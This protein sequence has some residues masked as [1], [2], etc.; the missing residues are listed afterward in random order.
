MRDPERIVVALAMLG[1]PLE[2]EAK[3]L[4]ADLG[5]TAY[6]VRLKLTAGL[7]AIVLSTVDEDAARAVLAKL[8]ARGHRALLVHAAAVVPHSAMV[9]MR[10]FELEPD[11]LVQTGERLPWGEI[12]ALVRARHHHQHDSVE[13]VKTKKFDLGRAV[14]SGGLIM[15]KTTTKEVVTHHENTEQVL[16]VFRGAG[17]VPWLLRQEHA[18]YSGLGTLLAPTAILN[19]GIAV[20]ELRK[21]APDARFDDSLIRRPIDDPD[22]FAHVIANS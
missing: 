4:A 12:T 8:R 7:P 13:K 22:L 21:R 5:S 3:A 2:A 9:I 16:Y 10:S 14:A 20:Q 17:E 6:E 11:A 18:N 15:R 19:F 1:T